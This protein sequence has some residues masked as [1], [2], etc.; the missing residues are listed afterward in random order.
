M[1]D[2]VRVVRA[3]VTWGDLADRLTLDDLVVLGDAVLRRGLA[4]LQDLTRIAGGS[5]HRRGLRLLSAGGFPARAAHRLAGR[6][7]S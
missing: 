1:R 6:A 5:R 2:G 4:S 7:S 3:D